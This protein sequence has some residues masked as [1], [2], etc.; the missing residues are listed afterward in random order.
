MIKVS[1]F[2]GTLGR[3]LAGIEEL[4]NQLEK[5]NES[6]SRI[7]S[8]TTILSLNAAVEASRSGAAGKGFA[9]VADE[10]KAL[11]ESSRLLA[12]HSDSNRVE[13]VAAIWKLM[14]ETEELTHSIADINDRLTNLAACTQEVFAESD[15][16]K[17]ISGT[18][19]SRLENLSY[20]D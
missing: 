18:V 1:E 15:V 3:S 19:K 10:V 5:N 13:I 7:A 11:A 8:Q 9:V 4:L 16:V 14:Q 2:C 17:G 20:R 12:E 6:I